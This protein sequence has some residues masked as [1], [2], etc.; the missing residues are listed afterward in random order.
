[1]C[2]REGSE[3]LHWGRLISPGLMLSWE[4]LGQAYLC[5][6]LKSAPHFLGWPLPM[7]VSWLRLR[8][9]FSLSDSEFLLLGAPRSAERLDCCPPGQGCPGAPHVVTLRGLAP[10]L[11]S[12]PSEHP[13]GPLLNVSFPSLTFFLFDS[14]FMLSSLSLPPHFKAASGTSVTCWV[15]PHMWRAFSWYRLS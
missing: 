6:L 14:C 1:M 11:C 2:P 8:K 9:V 15:L 10:W 12:S 5:L 7:P 3:E 4:V 13:F